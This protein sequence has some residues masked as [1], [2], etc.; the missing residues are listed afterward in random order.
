M[1]ISEATK[2]K[3]EDNLNKALEKETAESFNKFLDEQKPADK[4]EPKFREGDWITII[5]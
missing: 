3:L 5:E 4:V 2:Q 1:G